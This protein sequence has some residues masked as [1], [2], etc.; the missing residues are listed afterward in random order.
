[1]AT[2]GDFL[3]VKQTGKPVWK[4]T[5]GPV[6]TNKDHIKLWH[7][8]RTHQDSKG[9]IHQYAKVPAARV[10]RGPGKSFVVQFLM[11]TRSA[12][13]RTAG[14]LKDVRREL[15]FYLIE[16]SRPDRPAPWAY[17]RYHCTT[18][19]NFYSAVCWQWC[20]KKSKG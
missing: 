12:N 18:M 8:K 19:A 15:D 7:G 14:I 1:M 20:P 11:S 6:D 13:K 9:R 2:F 16:L 10:A 4:W 17:A 5:P 3:E